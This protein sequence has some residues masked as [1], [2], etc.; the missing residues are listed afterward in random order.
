MANNY[1]DSNDALQD[2]LATQRTM[3]Q[4][5]DDHT[6]QQARLAANSP[7]AAPAATLTA[8]DEQ[9]RWAFGTNAKATGKQ[10][11]QMSREHPERY[12]ALRAGA[13][14]LKLLS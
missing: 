3:K 4:I 2:A 1:A 7:T 11:T 6:A 12:A 5:H 14:R 13:V 10:L 9:V 8:T